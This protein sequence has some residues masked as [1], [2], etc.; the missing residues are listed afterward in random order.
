MK[1]LLNRNGISTWMAPYDIP[2]GSNFGEEVPK[3]IKESDCVILMLSN[4]SQSSHWV[5]REIVKAVSDGHTIIPVKIE[6]MILNDKFSF[7]FGE[8][9]ITAVQQIDEN[10]EE[11]INLLTRLSN[12]IGLTS[13]EK[14]S[15][16][17]NSKRI[18]QIKLKKDFMY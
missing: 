12:I 11:I 8:A 2:V 3:A 15:M 16:F 10:Q 6:D 14:K 1:D 9:Q 5:S 13:E 18:I 17:Q 7:Y 4:A